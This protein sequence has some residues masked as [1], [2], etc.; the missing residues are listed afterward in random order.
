VKLTN[1]HIVISSLAAIAG[2]A[3][4]GYQAF[5]PQPSAQQPVNVVVSLDQQQ[6]GDDVAK[7]DSPALMTETVNLA[8]GASFAAALKDGSDARYSFASLF[9][10]AADTFLA[11]AP[12]DQELNILVLF[13][14]TD[15]REVTALEYIPPA[16]VDPQ[17]MAVTV[18]VIVLPEGQLE[19]SG[20]PVISFS[21]PQSSETRTFAIPGRAEGKGLWLRVA[22]APGKDKSYVGDFRI[23]SESVA[24]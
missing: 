22:G 21:L 14:G 7:S 8:E 13:N 1:F 10:D 12:P 6:A 16:G 17:S 5:A 11:I 2:V 18:D 20:R 9:D 23:L 4:A 3:I 24:P 19:A 15:A